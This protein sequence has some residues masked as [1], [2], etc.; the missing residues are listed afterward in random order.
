MAVEKFR[1]VI[2][3]KHPYCRDLPDRGAD[4]GLHP[5]PGEGLLRRQLGGFP[6]APLRGRPVRRGRGGSGHPVRLRLLEEG[7]HVDPAPPKPRADRAV[8][9]VDKPAWSRPP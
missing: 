4:E 5:G 7:I 6:R 9:I 1:E 8:Y 2:Y 3:D